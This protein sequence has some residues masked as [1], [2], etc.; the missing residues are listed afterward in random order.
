V[1]GVVHGTGGPVGG[2]VN[3]RTMG[4]AV[5]GTGGPVGGV[6]RGMGGP[7]GGIVHRTGGP[8]GGAS[9]GESPCYRHLYHYI[10]V[11]HAHKSLNSKGV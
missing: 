10:Q 4:V 2:V 5:H 8:V 7:V 9:I 11:L 6:V 3:R 1:G